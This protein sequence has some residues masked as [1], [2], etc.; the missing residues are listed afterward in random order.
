MAVN[1]RELRNIKIDHYDP[2][3]SGNTVCSIQYVNTLAGRGPL[4]D[5]CFDTECP[6]VHGFIVSIQDWMPV[7]VLNDRLLWKNILHDVVG[8]RVDGDSELRRAKTLY[9][10]ALSVMPTLT[11]YIDE[12]YVSSKGAGWRTA[13]QDPHS[14]D[15]LTRMR[16]DAPDVSWGFV[17]EG[18]HDLREAT[19]NWEE[20]TSAQVGAR[21]GGA[22][23]KLSNV[24]R[25]YSMNTVDSLK[26]SFDGSENVLWW[27]NS[28]KPGEVLRDIL[29][30][31]EG[32]QDEV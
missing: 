26:R 27:R 10:W 4:D 22:I 12:M 18:C 1:E 23:G 19:L 14:V 31:Q 7:A 9:R 20:M 32:C 17:V 5:S 13:C 8:S 28:A 21:C 11:P 3:K 16:P 24:A 2:T 15:R 6:V 25:V 29:S 30:I